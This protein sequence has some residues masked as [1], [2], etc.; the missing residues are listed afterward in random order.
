MC[1]YR[2][3]LKKGVK[4]VASNGK[5]ISL[6]TDWWCGQLPLSQLNPSYPVNDFD[7]VSLLLDETGRWDFDQIS[8]L[9]HQQDLQSILNI[10]RLSFVSCF[11]T[12]IWTAS[13]C[14]AFTT[15]SA[16]K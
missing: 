10:P 14:G 13:S 5:D 1:K 6:W 4:W 3:A 15:T 16:Y 2:D 8:T 12:P 9:F 7:K 11:D